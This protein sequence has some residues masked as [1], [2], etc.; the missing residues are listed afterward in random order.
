MLVYRF[1]LALVMA[2]LF[3]TCSSTLP[4]EDDCGGCPDP[5]QCVASFCVCPPLDPPCRLDC[6]AG[7]ASCQRGTV[8]AETC[9]CRPIGQTNHLEVLVV[10]PSAVSLAPGEHH[11]LGATGSFSNGDILD[12]TRS[13]TWRSSDAAIATVTELSGVVTAVAEGTATITASAGDVAGHATVTVTEEAT[14]GNGEEPEDAVDVSH[15]RELRGAWVA[16]AWSINF[17]KTSG[18]ASQ[19]AELIALLDT[20]VDYGLNAIVFQVRPESD[21][22]YASELEPWSRFLTGT[23]GQ[24]PGYDPL[25]FLIEAAHARNIEVHAWLN[26]Y[27]GLINRNVTTPT[28]NHV[29]T[30]FS[31]Y[32]YPWGE[33]LLWMD[34][35]AEVVRD[36]I[37]DVVTDIVR[38]YDV[39]GIH[40][41]DYFYPWPSGG[42]EFPDG[43]LY[44]AYVADGGTMTLANWRRNNVDEM[45]RLVGEAVVAEKPHVR[46]GVSPFGIYRTGEP[47]GISGTS[48]YDV[49]FSDPKKWLQERWVDYI[50]PQL[51]WP[52]G[53][54]QDYATLLPWWTSIS[55]DGHYIFAG[56]ALYR[57]GETASWTVD[58]FRQQVQL[59]RDLRDQFSMGNIFYHVA[60]IQN[61]SS[62]VASMLRD[63]FYGAPALT[64]PVVATRDTAVSVPEVEVAGDVVTVSHVGDTPLRAWVVYAQDGQGWTLDRIVPAGE[65]SF[66]LPAG[67]WAISAASRG[68]VESRGVVVEIGD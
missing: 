11:Q 12:V 15:E 30:R 24:D 53:G 4:Q 46:F 42:A 16:T 57:L 65:S 38:R 7:D 27:R 55:E 67:T 37:V 36:H 40:F 19:Q 68:N 64:P 33:S 18:A 20:L 54:S 60:S 32:A 58:E 56:N 9:A 41:D 51:Y 34:P 39:D 62:G 35:G 47:P 61:D 2:A 21:A 22:F 14:N 25:A 50:A 45:I 5:H 43:D 6:E 44:D 49:L 66:S 23:L 8:D 52:H 26:P 28:A 13:V 10:N 31:E 3:A 59:G 1:L 63:E 17:P 48:Q 29:A